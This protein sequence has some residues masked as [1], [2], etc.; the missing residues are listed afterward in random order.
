MRMRKGWSSKLAI[1]ALI[2]TA[3]L[4]GKVLSQ[5]KARARRP[6]L[7]RA[8]PRHRP[9]SRIRAAPPPVESAT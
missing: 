6:R 9:R 2:L 3:A 5:D 4:A 1:G 7:R 8:A